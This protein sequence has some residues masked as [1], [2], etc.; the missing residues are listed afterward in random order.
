MQRGVGKF[1]PLPPSLLSHQLCSTTFTF[2]TQ[3]L[4]NTIDETF[5]LLTLALIHSS[6]LIF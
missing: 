2:I 6:I 5:E 3:H 1:Y 4:L